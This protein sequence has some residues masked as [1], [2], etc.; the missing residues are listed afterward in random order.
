MSSNA[1]TTGRSLRDGWG[2]VT[3]SHM[4]SVSSS[5]STSKRKNGFSCISTLCQLSKRIAPGLSAA[6]NALPGVVTRA[7]RVLS[8]DG[9]PVAE[10]PDKY[11]AGDE[12]SDMRPERDPA[13]VWRPQRGEAAEE[14]QGEPDADHHP[15]RHQ[16]DLTEVAEEDERPH[17]SVWEEDDVGAK[18]AGDR[19]RRSDQG[20][21]RGRTEEDLRETG[22]DPGQKIEEEIREVAHGV[23]D[24]VAEDEE[25]D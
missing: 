20:D 7:D 25:K 4:A 13:D 6:R 24:V 18:H 23:F 9:L 17:L 12:A 11:R 15:G 5:R 14:L 22:R 19:P 1:F 8:R 21:R 3:N 2:S 10:K 16:D